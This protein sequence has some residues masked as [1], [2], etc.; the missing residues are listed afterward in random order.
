M[1]QTCRMGGAANKNNN[2][3]NN[4]GGAA[5]NTDNRPCLL[6]DTMEEGSL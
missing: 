4:R 3:N 1:L 5:T 2:T 6:T